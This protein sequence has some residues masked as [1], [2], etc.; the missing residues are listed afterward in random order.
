MDPP[1]CIDGPSLCY[2]RLHEHVL[3]PSCGLHLDDIRLRANFQ[4]PSHRFSSVSYAR[5]YR[6]APPMQTSQVENLGCASYP[7]SP[8][9]RILE[10]EGSRGDPLGRK[11]PRH[12]H[13]LRPRMVQ[14]LARVLTT[15]C[16]MPHSAPPPRIRCSMW[17]EM[18][19]LALSC[20]D[21][22]PR[23]LRWTCTKAALTLMRGT[24]RL[25]FRRSTDP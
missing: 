3:C 25:R 22:V 9:I 15:S 23:W 6:A 10:D 13:A 14:H 7:P 2:M 18:P 24:R 12:W 11:L 4:P 17:G 8:I 16:A 21:L 5:L 20:S 19:T 1:C